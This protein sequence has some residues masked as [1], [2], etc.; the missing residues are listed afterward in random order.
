MGPDGKGLVGTRGGREVVVELTGC[1]SW[2]PLGRL[3]CPKL[4]LLG[5]IRRTKGMGKGGVVPR[6]LPS[7]GAWQYPLEQRRVL[8][9]AVCLPPCRFTRASK[10]WCRMRTTM[11]LQEQ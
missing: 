9:P 6:A 5:T 11:A 1:S 10:G 8:E 2:W 7:S 3:L 4:A